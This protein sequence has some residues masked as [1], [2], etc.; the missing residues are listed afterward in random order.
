MMRAMMREKIIALLG[1]GVPATQVASA[2]G[3]S[4]SYV[5][6]ILSEEGVQEKVQE[7]RTEKAMR[8]V[9]HDEKLDSDEAAALKLVRRNIHNGFLKPME[10]LRHFQILNAAR[11]RSDTGQT[12]ADAPSTV[13]ALNIPAAAIVQFKLTHERQVIEVEGRSLVPLPAAQVAKMARERKAVEQLESS[14]T[15]APLTFDSHTQALLN[16]L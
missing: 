7:L 2:C 6:Q 16:E 11:R 12:Q 5:S 9:E 8:Y 3:V 13:I 15:P 4:D 14:L 10:T 1:S